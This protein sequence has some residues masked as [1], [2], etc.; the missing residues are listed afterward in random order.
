MKTCTVKACKIPLSKGINPKD[1]QQDFSHK[2]LCVK[3]ARSGKELRD[4]KIFKALLK[5]QN[6]LDVASSHMEGS[7]YLSY[8][9]QKLKL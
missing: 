8:A 6:S 4:L 9:L 5:K 1:H 2:I 7:K 3:S